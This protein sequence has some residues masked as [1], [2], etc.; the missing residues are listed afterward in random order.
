M[1]GR[2]RGGGRSGNSSRG[3]GSRGRGTGGAGGGVG[4]GGAAGR[5]VRCAC[6]ANVPLLVE[7]QSFDEECL[8]TGKV[9]LRHGLMRAM[10]SLK[11]YPL[12]V[13]TE[14]EACALEGVGGFTARR[15]LRGL[16][17]AAAPAT[18]N[19]G[20][21]GGGGN[22]SRRTDEENIEPC[23]TTSS[24]SSSSRGGSRKTNTDGS[25][26]CGTSALSSGAG[27]RA[28][29]NNS[30][31]GLLR[32]NLRV[33][34]G[35]NS[36][37]VGS[38]GTLSLAS[39]FSALRGDVADGGGG[40]G[41]Q[42]PDVTP[43][44]PTSRARRE[45]I[46]G[47]A[48][49]GGQPFQSKAPRYFT[50]YWEAWLLVDNRE[51]A[52]M[53]MQ[54]T[55][56]QKGI[57]CE[58]RQLPLGD[59]LWIARR[60]DDPTSEVLLG[61]IVER[62]TV[63]DLASS[64]IDGRYDEQKRRLKLSGLRRP[65]YLVEG[66]IN[67]QGILAPSTLRTALAS[68]QTCGS[69]AV[70]QCDSLRDSVDFLAR[71]HRHIAALLSDPCRCSSGSGGG[72][73]LWPSGDAAGGVRVGG[74]GAG[75]GVGAMLRPAMTY[76]EYAQSCAKHAGET[77]VKQL[78]GAMARQV[79]GCSAARAQALVQEFESPLG[80]MLA[81]ERAAEGAYEGH[82][83]VDD[84]TRCKRVDALLTDLECRGR[85]GTNK[86]PQPMRRLLCRLFLGESAGG[87]GGGGGVDA[88]GQQHPAAD[89]Q[90]SSSVVCFSGSDP[91]RDFD[92]EPMNQDDPYL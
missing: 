60:K 77:T 83:G 42:T 76:G 38:G 10:K 19:N 39:N 81:F 89:R 44:R 79:P 90:E 72:D 14:K 46:D 18:G 52:F 61:Y 34:G 63:S 12:P 15:M 49:A 45:E 36:R 31:S 32:M 51:T 62:K 1:T 13:T 75:P 70:V 21:G 4:G 22:S 68:S 2:G 6:E 20:G 23:R 3:R 25:R 35:G 33:D 84:A 40:G 56:L 87:A 69:L 66:N 91:Y 55:L 9:K 59:M 86:L 26:A 5:D 88:G 85:A 27:C 43:K 58:T 82:P 29:S 24:S 67:H 92:V 53:S 30:A 64:I 41:V 7:L 28:S 57:P 50:G 16:L 73:E 78:L 80:L 47:G 54:S 71:T 37:G 74:G 17:P 8:R 48:T 11:R 65:I